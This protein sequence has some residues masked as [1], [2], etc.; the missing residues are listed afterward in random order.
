MSKKRSSLAEALN[1]PEPQKQ[2]VKTDQEQNA[3]IES[4]ATAN[5]YSQP[6]SRRGKKPLTV[7]LD[8]AVIKQL[9]MIGL[10]SDSTNQDMVIEALNDF[11]T[12]HGKPPI[13]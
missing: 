3:A 11:F 1:R 12:K 8:P 5:T 4:R 6:P 2:N 10:E 9:K 13:A 7:Y